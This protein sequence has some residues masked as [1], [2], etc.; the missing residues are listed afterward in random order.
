MLRLLFKVRPVTPELTAAVEAGMAWFSAHQIENH[1]DG[2]FR[3]YDPSTQKPFFPCKFDGKAYASDE[4][5]RKNNPGGYDFGVKSAK[6][7]PN[8]HAKWLKVLAEQK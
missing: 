7:L 4:A 8:Y 3:F 2:W 1:P 6:E 5:M